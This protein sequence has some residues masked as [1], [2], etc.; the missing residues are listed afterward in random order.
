[1]CVRR[2]LVGGQL[3]SAVGGGRAIDRKDLVQP[4]PGEQIVVALVG[5]DDVHLALADF[6]QAQGDAGERAHERRIHHRAIRQINHEIAVAAV[7]H[8][9][10]ETF[11]P[12]AVLERAFA[13]HADADHFLV[14]PYQDRGGSVHVWVEVEYTGRRSLLSN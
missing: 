11:D 13:L 3:I 7:N 6:A 1:M 12:S 8:G 2:H 14:A 5:V 4:Q 10:G 9:R